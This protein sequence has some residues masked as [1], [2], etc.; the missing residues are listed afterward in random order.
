M[1][2]EKR[3][4]QELCEAASKEHDPQQLKALIAELVKAFDE[5]D[6][7]T[8]PGNAEQLNPAS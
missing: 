3:D 6:A 2:I 7:R 8:H 1:S 5:R 4:W